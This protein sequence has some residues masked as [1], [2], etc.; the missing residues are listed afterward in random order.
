MKTRIILFLFIVY[1]AV[2][3]NA[4]SAG[5]SGMSFLKFG[6]GPR[7]IAMGDIGAASANDISALQYNPALL[8]KTNSYE[9]IFM[10]NEWIQD[11]RSEYLGAGFKLWGVPFAAGFNYS[12]V[13]DIEARLLPGE[14]LSTF[15]ADYFAATLSSGFYVSQYL[16]IGLSFKYLYEGIFAYDAAGYAFDFGAFYDLTAYN[17]TLGIAA[18]NLG[19]MSELRSESTKLPSELRLGAAYKMRV[20][21]ITSYLA[22]GS[23]AVKYLENDEMYYHFGGELFFNDII[24]IRAGYQAGWESRGLTAGAGLKW[25]TLYFDYALIPFNYDLG[26]GHILS[27]K[28]SF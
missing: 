24:A 3:L 17:I 13:S 19:S 11:V 28:Y 2:S 20:E 8:A 18:K 26:T 22:L 16:G 10:H 21:S 9:L 1:S 12:G 23:D 27:L 6:F 7:N 5:N 14:P 25:G 4:Q 15:S